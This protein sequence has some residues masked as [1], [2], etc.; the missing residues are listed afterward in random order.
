[1][2]FFDSNKILSLIILFFISLIGVAQQ[3]ADSTSTAFKEGRWL[4]GLSGSISSTR[5]QI[6]SSDNDI[7]SNNFGF[8]IQTG[9]FLK[10]R[11]LVG[12]VFQTNRINSAG[13]IEQSTETLFIGPF[14]NYYFSNNPSGSIFGS[15]AVGYTRFQNETTFMQDSIVNQENSDGGGIGT[16]IG[17]GYS[18]TI[19]K[20]IAFDLGVN[21][22]LFWVNIDQESLPNGNISSSNLSSSDVSFSFGFNVLLDNFFF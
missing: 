16:I 5:T 17:L 12:G 6:G 13:S 19:T 14:S 3:N 20:S 11:F 15:L 8:N 2:K 7:S 4:T 9:K 18:Y 1:M 21:V 22:N 10:D